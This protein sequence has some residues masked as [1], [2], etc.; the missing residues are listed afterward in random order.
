MKINPILLKIGKT[1]EIVLKKRKKGVRE[2]VVIIVIKV[3][4]V[5]GYLIASLKLSRFSI[6][7][8][9][10]LITQKIGSSTTKAGTPVK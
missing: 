5:I 1:I 2:I 6:A 10:P 9:T 3:I 4:I 7:M 8:P